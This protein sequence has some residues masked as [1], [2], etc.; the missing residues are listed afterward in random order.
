MLTIVS[1]EIMPAVV[2]YE[3]ELALG[4]RTLREVNTKLGSVQ[5]ALLAD[6]DTLLQQLK[7]HYETLENAHA[8]ASKA[9][10]VKK[11]AYIYRDQVI[12]AM[13]ELRD[14]S[15]K[16]ENIIPKTFGLSRRTPTYS[17]TNE[18]RKVA[19]SGE[20]ALLYRL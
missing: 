5:S 20:I 13:N 10:D 6:V 2:R 18:T 7:Y 4:V 9:G 1:R 16:L 3:G 14:V 11:Q 12:P 8:V 15:D 19:E 17:S